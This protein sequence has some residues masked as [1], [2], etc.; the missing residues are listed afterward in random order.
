MLNVCNKCGAKYFKGESTS[1]GVYTWRYCYSGR[2]ALEQLRNHEII[3]SLMNGSHHMSKDFL[4]NIRKYINNSLAFV[5]TGYNNEHHLGRGPGCLRV[6]AEMR[7]Y[8]GSLH[9]SED[10]ERVY[11]AQL[12]VL[13]HDDS[14]V[15][16][17]SRT[18]KHSANVGCNLELIRILSNIMRNDSNPFSAAWKMMHEV[19]ISVQESNSTSSEIMLVIMNDRQ[20]DNRRYNNA[21]QQT[22][23]VAFVFQIADEEPPLQRDLI[24]HSKTRDNFPLQRISIVD[25][26]SWGTRLSFVFP[27]WW[28]KFG[29]R[30]AIETCCTWKFG[31]IQQQIHENES[32][33]WWSTIHTNFKYVP[34]SINFCVEASCLSSKSLMHTSRWRQTDWTSFASTKINWVLPATLGC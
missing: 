1:S 28:P 21:P 32:L 9:L 27:L 29:E 16:S 24:I 17:R 22:N 10:C 20:Q 34:I 19:E 3:Q 13:D 30:A 25:P 18:S 12:H 26:Q 7:H 4:I 33:R 2:V 23:E 6:I 8:A 11:Y 31:K 14:A 15:R 5:S